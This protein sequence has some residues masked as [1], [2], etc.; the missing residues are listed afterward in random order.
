MRVINGDCLKVME[1]FEDSSIDMIL[2]D[3]PYQITKSSWDRL[4][5]LELIW[6]Q[7]LRIIK[8]NCA[9]VLTASQPFTSILVSSNLKH[10]K[11]EWIWEKSK[12]SNF[13][14]ARKQPLKAHESILV[15]S[16]GTPRY[17]PQKTQGKPYSGEGRA[18]K[19]GSQTELV[20]HVPSPTKRAGSL[21]GT[22]FPRSVQYFRTAESEG[23][24]HP[25]QKPLALMEYLVNTYTLEGEVVLDSFSGS[26]TTGV[27]CKNLGRDCILIEK[28]KKYFDTMCRRLEL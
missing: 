21:D 20:N 18:G 7:Y 9:I 22:R 26:G 19:R 11:Y 15:F 17:Y 10:F 5:P 4:P 25:T 27:A 28:E 3:P 13:L 16:K 24:F 8:P 14:L 23:R 12:A 6:K 2:C 1:S